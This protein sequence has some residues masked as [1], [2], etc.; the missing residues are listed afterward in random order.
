MKLLALLFT[1]GLWVAGGLVAM[2]FNWQFLSGFV[3]TMCVWGMLFFWRTFGGG[4]P[5]Q[6]IINELTQQN[7]WAEKDIENLTDGRVP[8]YRA[9]TKYLRE[10]IAK[11]EEVIR[12][13]K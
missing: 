11:R 1:I 4:S 2:L 6:R 10:E 3:I 13:L 8:G 9:E 5:A 12:E 7:Y